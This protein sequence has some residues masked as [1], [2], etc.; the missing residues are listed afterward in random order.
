MFN[1]GNFLNFFL[2]PAIFEYFEYLVGW[3]DAFIFFFFLALITSSSFI[4][5]FEE[6]GYFFAEDFSIRYDDVAIDFEKSQ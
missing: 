5:T 1:N 6:W 3:T 4:H 2:L